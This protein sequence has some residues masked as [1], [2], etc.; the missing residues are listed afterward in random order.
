M[1]GERHFAGFPSNAG[2]LASRGRPSLVI[3]F[4]LRSNAVFLLASLFLPIAL[5]SP[6]GFG[7]ET[8]QNLGNDHISPVTF[9]KTHF[10]SVWE[11]SQ[12]FDS[13][14]KLIVND[15]TARY[16]FDPRKNGRREQRIFTECSLEDADVKGREVEV[17]QGLVKVV[18]LIQ[19][20]RS[21]RPFVFAA[22]L[23][24][25]SGT[26]TR[27]QT[28]TQIRIHLNLAHGFGEMICFN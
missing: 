14:A 5:S 26:G 6:F 16:A 17:R 3:L 9:K 10:A 24:F 15:M 19:R 11:V 1:D 12:I 8:I 28:G 23:G 18:R 4:F 21:L 7:A 25:K 20:V 22:T 13:F 2:P 27:T